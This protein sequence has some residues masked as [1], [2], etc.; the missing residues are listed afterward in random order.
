MKFIE[1]PKETFNKVRFLDYYMEGHAGFIAGGSFKNIF[2]KEKIKDLDIF[3]Q[4]EKDFK[5]AK[6]FFENN[7]DYVFSYENQ[8]TISFKNKK[9]NIRVEL[10]CHTYG[11]PIE[12]ISMFDF[13]ITRYAYAKK[14]EGD[15]IVY[16]NVYVDT[17]FED[18]ISNK[19]VIDGE[20]KFPV[21]S[22]E[23]SY[24]YRSYGY[25][26]CKESKAKLLEALQTANIDDLSNDLY[27]GL[28]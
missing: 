17:F 5:D 8:N 25:G 4:S 1:K 19:L 20:L 7:E 18:L 22:F 28:D 26:L 2:K 9:T 11:T 21:S 16:Y 23:R 27:F 12:I 14:I 24:R 3:F 13:S 6:V 10:I 15:G